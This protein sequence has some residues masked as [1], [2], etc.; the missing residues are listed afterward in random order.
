MGDREGMRREG[1]E[2]RSGV[3][4]GCFMHLVHLAAAGDDINC[5]YVPESRAVGLPVC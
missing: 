1:R 5:C 4:G 2:Q 3:T